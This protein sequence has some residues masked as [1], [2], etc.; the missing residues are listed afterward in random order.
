MGNRFYAYGILER[1]SDIFYLEVE[2]ALGLVSGTATTSDL[3]GL[4]A[5]RQAEY[6]RYRDEMEPPPDSFETYGMVVSH[7]QVRSRPGTGPQEAGLRDG[8]TGLL[9]GTGCCPGVVSGAVRVVTDPRS[10]SV[11]PGEILVAERT[12]PGW[13]LLFASAAGLVVE[14]GS[15]LSHSAIVAR[16][17][18]IPAV[19]S[20]P[21]A[22]RWLQTGD[23]IQL[24]GGSGIITR[25]PP[26][27]AEAEAAA[28]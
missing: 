1:P 21:G 17:L 5:V 25:I 28:S 26:P 15:L 16:E 18:G 4:V 23:W 2:E 6:A 14:H 13:V 20:A 8:T 9:K 7:G 10:E 24:D 27:A 12:D 11:R 3:K 19:V 22:T